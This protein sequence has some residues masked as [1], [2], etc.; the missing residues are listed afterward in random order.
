MNRWQ[1]IYE[2]T[3]IIARRSL[4]RSSKGWTDNCRKLTAW[5]NLVLTTTLLK[6]DLFSLR[7]LRLQYIRTK[8]LG[9]ATVRHLDFFETA[10]RST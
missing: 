1:P 6:E 8:L 10:L 4:F 9:K 7:E 5:C 2:A 3:P